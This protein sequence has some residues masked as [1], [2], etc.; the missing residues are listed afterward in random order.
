[1][2]QTHDVE[3]IL[4]RCQ[5]AEEEGFIA[6]TGSTCDVDALFESLSLQGYKGPKETEHNGTKLWINKQAGN[7]TGIQCPIFTNLASLWTNFRERNDAPAAFYYV[8]ESEF[9]ELR[10]K[11]DVYFRWKR[12]LKALA[13]HEGAKGRPHSFIFFIDAEKGPT[14]FEIN[15]LIGLDAFLEIEGNTENVNAISALEAL[16][17]IEEDIH[18]DERRRILRA[19]LAELSDSAFIK[20]DFVK[21]ANQ[22]I[23]F[24]KKYKDL[25]E[26]YARRFSVNKLLNEIDEKTTD[27]L[28]KVQD[29][30][31][32]SQTKAY[33]LPGALIGVAALVKSV[34]PLDF[35]LVISGFCFIWYLTKVANDISREAYRIISEQIDKS[36][37]RYQDL[38]DS[39]TGVKD[40]AA[41]KKAVL[42]TLLKKANER[43]DAIDNLAIV[44]L[45]LGGLYLILRIISEVVPNLFLPIW[46]GFWQSLTNYLLAC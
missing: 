16:L 28:A 20:N 35:I 24:R 29:S 31:A 25:Y 23:E 38:P 32:S 34:S 10:Q 44:M 26:L 15:P 7:W 11:L 45:V 42:D 22:S 3:S 14:K 21:L 2:K 39:N 27:Y 6:V 9:P 18:S 41:E 13:D 5:L 30:I 19:S 12:T 8:G 1:M 40:A 36:F 37:S 46:F 43:L 4:S 33:A 17:S